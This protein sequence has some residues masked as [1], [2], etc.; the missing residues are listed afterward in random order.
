MK[1][2][3]KK[4]KRRGNYLKRR[5]K[6]INTST[7]TGHLSVQQ[8]VLDTSFEIDTGNYPTGLIL[9]KEFFAA[10]IPQWNNFAALFDQYRICGVKVTMLPTSNQPA[11]SNTAATFASSIDLDGDK[12]ISTFDDL[13]QCSNTKTSPWSAAGGLT[14]YKSVYCKPRCQNAIVRTLGADGQPA[15]YSMALANRKAWIDV[16]DQGLTKHHGINFGWYFGNEQV[17]NIQLVNMVVTYYI[18]FRKIR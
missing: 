15:T 2:G 11:V 16:A 9:K 6:K 4:R 12:T 1:R 3:Y 14:P 10:E 7:R 13:L 17:Q 8:K 5:Y 18:Q